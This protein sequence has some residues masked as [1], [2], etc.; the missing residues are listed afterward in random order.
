MKK[1]LA[2]LDLNLLITLQLLLQERS[3]S[4]AAKRLNLTPS[5][6]SKALTKLRD[7]FEDPL[8]VKTPY[9]LS[10]TNLAIGLESELAEWS[11]IGRQIATTRGNTAPR[12]LVLQIAVENPLV[13]TFLNDLTVKAQQDFPDSV[14]KVRDWDYDSLD[15]LVRGEIDIGFSGRESHPRSKESI[16]ELPYFID[17]EILFADIPLVYLRDDHPALEEEWNLETYLKYRHINIV[18]E[19]RETWALDDILAEQGIAR[20]IGMTASGFDQSLFIASQPG[21]TLMTT[22]PRYS[23]LLAA[24]YHSRLVTRPI[25]VSSEEEHKLTT[26]FTLMWHKRNAHNPKVKWLR[27]T[28]KA[29]IQKNIEDNS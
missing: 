26:P 27:D 2:R 11:R 12:G 14:M 24:D 1:S 6:V 23:R 22:A 28:I 17:H 19:K 25:P 18:W 16:N 13:L 8:F 5:A 9:G 20:K 7:W 29:L 10:P 15:A 3:V 4:K 21:H